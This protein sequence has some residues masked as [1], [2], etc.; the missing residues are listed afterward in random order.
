[1]KKVKNL[2]KK[3]PLWIGS[4]RF[5]QFVSSLGWNVS[6]ADH[7]GFLGGLDRKTLSTGKEAPYYADYKMELLF[8]VPTMMPSSKV[9][10]QQ[11]HKVCVHWIN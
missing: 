3:W 4:E 1:M 2:K 11:I 8:H 9:E 7:T 10:L 5:Q 6:V